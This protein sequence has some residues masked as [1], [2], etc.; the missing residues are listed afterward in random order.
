MRRR[1]P[2]P[3]GLRQGRAE[4][5]TSPTLQSFIADFGS[6]SAPRPSTDQISRVRM[7]PSWRDPNGNPNAATPMRKPQPENPNPGKLTA[8][9]SA[10]KP[11]RSNSTAQNPARH[12]SQRPQ[13]GNR[14]RKSQPG[15]AQCHSGQRSG[16]S[17]GYSDAGKVQ[18]RPSFAIRTNCRRTSPESLTGSDQ[19]NRTTRSPRP[20]SNPSTSAVTIRQSPSEPA[21]AARASG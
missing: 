16:G 7:S 17:R 4:G 9:S 11:Q 13:A 15:E 18:P 20:R 8:A 14:P 6:A 10:R 21:I 3:Q 5:Q 19:A 2:P 1:F 12:P